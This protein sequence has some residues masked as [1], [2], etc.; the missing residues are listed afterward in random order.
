M[1]GKLDKIIIWLVIISGSLLGFILFDTIRFNS[2]GPRY[3]AC[4][5]AEH[6]LYTG[7][8]DEMPEECIQ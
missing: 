1:N 6:E 7:F 8:I 5:G 2:V 3:T 4:D